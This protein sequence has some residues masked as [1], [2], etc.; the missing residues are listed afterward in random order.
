MYVSL[1]IDIYVHASLYIYKYVHE[2]VQISSGEPDKV[3]RI[4]H[5]T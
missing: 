1:C 2:N 3:H 4:F 5:G